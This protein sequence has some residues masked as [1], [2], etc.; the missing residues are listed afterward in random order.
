MNKKKLLAQIQNNSKNVKYSDFVVLIEAFGFKPIRSRGSHN[1]FERIDIPELVNIQ[2]N[3]GNA[4]PYQVR[5]FLSLV[6]KYSLQLE[7]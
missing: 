2:N 7:D 6:E 3:K 4:K 1:I 5:Q